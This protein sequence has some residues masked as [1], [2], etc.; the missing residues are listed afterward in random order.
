[1]S[2]EVI[3]T[4][5]RGVGIGKLFRAVTVGDQ[6]LAVEALNDG[7]AQSL[8]I[9]GKSFLR[10]AGERGRRNI[11]HLLVKYGADPNEVNG[12]RRYSL[13]HNA[14]A[15]GNYGFASI[16]L[17]LNANP[18]PRNS[19]GATPLHFAARTNQGFLASKLID[20][21]ADVNAVDNRG[22]TPI[23]LAVSKGHIELAKLFVK[24]NCNPAIPDQSG[25]KPRQ[26]AEAMGIENVF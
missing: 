4:T 21:G 20:G 11:C 3:C 25:L 8:R 23:Y 26:I 12:C 24:A 7:V 6:H 18:T 14:A 22:R 13:L 10:H 9:L 15:S 17:E 2:Q 1:M 5:G 19:S 16:L